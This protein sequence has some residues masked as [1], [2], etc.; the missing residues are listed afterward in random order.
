MSCSVCKDGL[1]KDG[2]FVSCGKCDYKMHFECSGIKKSTWKSKTAKAKSDWEC[3]VCKKKPRIQ[4]VNSDEDTEPDDPIYNALKKFLEGMFERQEQRIVERVNN[5]T[6]LVTQMEERFMNIIENIK[7]LEKKTTTFQKDLDELR[8]DIEMEKQYSRSRNFV[9]TNIPI[10]EKEDV[11]KKVTTLLTK[12]DIQL[13]GQ[14]I[15]AHRLPANKQHP[16]P[17]LVQCMTRSIRDK[18]VRKARKYRP[19]VKLIS[20]NHPDKPIFFNDHL[21]PYYSGLMA[22]VNQE[23]K[24][25]GYQFVWMNGNRIMVKKDN[26]S[27][28]VQILKH[29]DLGKIE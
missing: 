29:E 22:K 21:T 5:I 12:M 11:E 8:M 7:E 3:N 28:A 6:T 15:T 19:T 14:S 1:P 4:S 10:T 23:R 16:A 24:N 18:V 13:E 20:N 25:K 27:K 2:D 9:I 17:I 26:S